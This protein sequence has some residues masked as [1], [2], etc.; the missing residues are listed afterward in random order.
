MSKKGYYYDYRDDQAKYDAWCYIIFGGRATGKT[1]SVLRYHIEEKSKF[2][3]IKRTKDD[4]RILCAG[5]TLH[6]P[7]MGE[8]NVDMSPFKSLN[9]DF[10]WRIRGFQIDKGLGAFFNCNEE[11]EPVGDPVGYVF[12]LA[13]ISQFRGFDLSECDSLIFDEFVP[14]EYERRR[15]GEGKEILDLYKT[16]SRDREHRGFKPLKLIALANPDD[17]NSPL[18]N[19]LEVMEDLTQMELYYQGLETKEDVPNLIEDR[20]IFLHKILNNEEYMERERNTALMKAMRGTTFAAMSLDNEFAYND[21]SNIGKVNM[22]GYKPLCK[23]IHNKKDYYIYKNYMTGKVYITRS[24]KVNVKTTYNLERD[25]DRRRFYTNIVIDL[26]E[27]LTYDMTTFDS[28]TMY[29]II[30]NFKDYY[31]I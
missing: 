6:N 10:G 5:A 29:D 1:Y 31:K 12:A 16:I 23:I 22:K 15:R 13:A 11:D 8:F 19:I 26:K 25:A 27:L 14:K 20:G 3:F 18:V 17:I 24:G 21:F 30:L 2:V 7:R 9:R 4:V 28:Y